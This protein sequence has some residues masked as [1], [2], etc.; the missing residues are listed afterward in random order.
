MFVTQ[1][2]AR[3]HARLRLPKMGRMLQSARMLASDDVK[4]QGFLANLVAAKNAQLIC[5]ARHS[6][7]VLRSCR[8]SAAVHE[9]TQQIGMI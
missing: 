1:V 8:E 9:S 5:A 6:E 7:S 2:S 4:T 3:F